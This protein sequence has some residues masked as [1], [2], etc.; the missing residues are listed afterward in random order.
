MYISYM[1]SSS[2]DNKVSKTNYNDLYIDRS[3]DR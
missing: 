1:I 2:I 3:I